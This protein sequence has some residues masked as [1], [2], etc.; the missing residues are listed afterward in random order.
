MFALPRL[1]KKSA[2]AEQIDMP[3]YWDFIKNVVFLLGILLFFIGWIY[4]Y[5]YF[6]NFGIP[7][8]DIKI[9]VFSYY[10]YGFA[11]LLD[12]YCAI[13]S[14]VYFLIF[15]LLYFYQRRNKLYYFIISILIISIFP[16]YHYFAR[17]YSM[18]NVRQL[19]NGQSKS[20][21]VF[22][23]FKTE[24]LKP[25]KASKTSMPIDRPNE[26]DSVR[27]QMLLSFMKDYKVKQFFQNAYAN[28]YF[29]NPNTSQNGDLPIIVYII[30]H[31]KISYSTV[32]IDQQNLLKK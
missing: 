2:P 22:L 30:E 31:D 29:V 9:D 11:V 28:Y 24:T 3:K 15:S 19:L 10:L 17:Y 23:S 12:S 18:E 6:E 1:K 26:D 13:T 16:T 14:G 4:L 21:P 7:I 32:F 27:F 25:G 5:Y 20:S 8:H